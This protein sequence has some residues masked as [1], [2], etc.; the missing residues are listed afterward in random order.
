MCYV[1]ESGCLITGEK[2]LDA[3]GSFQAEKSSDKKALTDPNH[4]PTTQGS[5]TN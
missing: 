3:F 5:K 4:V 2:Y 1:P